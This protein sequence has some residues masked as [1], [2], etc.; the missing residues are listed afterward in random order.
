MAWI[1]IAG[2]VVCPD[3]GCEWLPGRLYDD[4]SVPAHFRHLFRWVEDQPAL[5][6]PKPKTKRKRAKDGPCSAC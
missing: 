1:T 2:R 6:P 4:D 5:P 3:I